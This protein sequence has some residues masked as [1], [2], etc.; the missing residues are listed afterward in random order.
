MDDNEGYG[1]QP[2]DLED[3]GAES[4]HSRH[5]AV[6]HDPLRRVGRV[7]EVP[8][9]RGAQNTPRRARREAPLK[10][11]R[12]QNQEFVNSGVD[13]IEDFAENWFFL[14]DC[15]IGLS[16]FLSCHKNDANSDQQQV[17]HHIMFGNILL[18]QI[19]LI[20][21]KTGPRMLS[22]CFVTKA[23]VDEALPEQLRIS[24]GVFSWANL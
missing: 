13:S 16:N 22:V 12:H 23:P 2:R 20:L 9:T 17:M 21:R 1:E 11:A 4:E 8:E 7:A 3:G 19:M 14:L 15:G 10:F 24:W 18:L 6:L 5:S